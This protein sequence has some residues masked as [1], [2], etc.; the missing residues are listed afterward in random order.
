MDKKNVIEEKIYKK[1]FCKYYTLLYMFASKYV[2]SDNADDI[3]Q[4]VFL[5]LWES[6][7]SFKNEEHIKLYLYKSTHH[8]C[9]NY[10]KHQQ[11]VEKE[12]SSLSEISES[13]LDFHV[14][15]EHI[16]NS[17]L[18]NIFQAIDNLPAKCKTIFILTYLDDMSTQEIAK[19][20]HISINTIKTQRL[21]AKEALREAL[22]DIMYTLLSLSNILLYK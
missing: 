14:E 18:S 19:K 10:I 11:Y 9:L 21:R 15:E 22:K 16:E 5:K 12:L 20:L 17:I 13:Q 6:H 1:I 8:S 3:V 4:D 2:S 7:T